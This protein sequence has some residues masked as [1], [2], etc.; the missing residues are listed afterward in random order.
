MH[1]QDMDSSFFFKQFSWKWGFIL[2]KAP[3]NFFFFF[4]KL[5]FE[6]SSQAWFTTSEFQQKID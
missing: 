3:A 5:G 2:S 4:K 1:D 6:W